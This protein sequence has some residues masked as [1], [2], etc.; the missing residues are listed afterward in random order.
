MEGL[1]KYSKLNKFTQSPS[2][3]GGIPRFRFLIH[4]ALIKNQKSALEMA[5]GRVSKIAS[6]R[7]YTSGANMEL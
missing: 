6:I 1:N 7:I 3:V 2:I 5:W 4:M